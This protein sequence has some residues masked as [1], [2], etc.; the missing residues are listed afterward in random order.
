MVNADSGAI[1]HEFNTGVGT[2]AAEAGLAQV[3]AYAEPDGSV[4]YA[5]GGDLLGNLWRFD[6]TAKGS[7]TKIAQ[8]RGPGGDVQPVTTAPELVGVAGQR[9]VVIGTGRLLDIGDFG[10]AAVQSIYAIADGALLSNARTSL[11]QQTYTRATD[12]LSDN[13]VDWSS[14]RGWYLDLP[15]GEQ[16]NTRPTIAYGGLAFVS[17]RNGGSDCS[18]S[19]W[20]YVVDVLD[21]SRFAGAPG[22]ASLISDV[23]NSSGVTA[24]LTTGQKIIGSGQNADGAPWNRE[25]TAGVPIDPSKNAW[26]EVRR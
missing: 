6:L 9:V 7:P 4:R 3:A 10:N 21:G 1:V 8:L 15:A 12:S 26:R 13:P 18:A 24:L 16:V 25:I 17:N 23:S 19:S 22:V 14:G 2:L 11:V 5:Y 20:L